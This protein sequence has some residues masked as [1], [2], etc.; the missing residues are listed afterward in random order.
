LVHPSVLIAAFTP[1]NQKSN[2]EESLA[3]PGKGVPFSPITVTKPIATAVPP[4]QSSITDP[5]SEIQVS[6]YF[7]PARFWLEKPRMVKM[8][9]NRDDC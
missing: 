2:I 8:Q 3:N 5:H 1:G 7:Q 6:L 9:Q 4:G